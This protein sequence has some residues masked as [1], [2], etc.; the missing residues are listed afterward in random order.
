MKKLTF[1]LAAILLI[2]ACGNSNKKT[3]KQT[4]N[5]TPRTN[6][7]LLQA[8]AGSASTQTNTKAT[9]LF[10]Q[11]PINQAILVSDFDTF[12]ELAKNIDTTKLDN[13]L[14]YAVEIC[15]PYRGFAPG[16][17]TKAVCQ[18]EN[19]AKIIQV[20]ANLG[21]KSDKIHFFIDEGYT[22]YQAKTIVSNLKAWNPMAVRYVVARLD[23]CLVALTQMQDA[24]DTKAN[25]YVYADVWRNNNCSTSNYKTTHGM[26]TQEDLKLYKLIGA[27][28][29]AVQKE[30]G[31]EPTIYDHPSE[32]R[33]V[34]T[35][36]T[37]HEHH[38][39][40]HYF[41]EEYHYIFTIDRGV[42]TKVQRMHISTTNGK[43]DTETIDQE[44]LK[45]LQQKRQENFKG[46]PTGAR[47]KV[48]RGG[49]R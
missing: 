17:T 24:D 20:L 11:E 32:H 16:E 37:A 46:K 35:Y 2:S 4:T 18:K 6:A 28:K 36:K 27:D 13:Y 30:Y 23:K 15:N 49:L 43:G 10:A 34:L 25:Y 5:T 12:S 3:T 42:V 38:T 39:G 41:V 44:K 8:L 7:M 21:A 31:T 40:V 33:E 29:A 9:N 1:L 48:M 19:N 26:S 22:N 47:E 14:S 45:Q